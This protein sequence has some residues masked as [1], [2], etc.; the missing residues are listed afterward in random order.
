MDDLMRWYN[1]AVAATVVIAG[2]A[3]SR[4]WAAFSVPERLHWQATAVLNLTAL[5]GTWESLRAGYPGGLR[6]Y[7]LAV[8]VTWL[9]AAV[10]HDPLTRWRTRRHATKES[11]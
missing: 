5:I 3:Q 2:T 8:G 7:L 10:L 4:R 1:V 11:P 9:L 6:V